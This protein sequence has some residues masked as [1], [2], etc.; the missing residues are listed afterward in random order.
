MELR[1]GWVCPL[2]G[3]ALSPDTKACSCYKK[4]EDI[5][6]PTAKPVENIKDMIRG[7]LEIEDHFKIFKWVK[8][9]PT[10]YDEQPKFKFYTTSSSDPCE[11]CPSKEK[12]FCHCTLKSKVTY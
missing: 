7:P 3:K 2:C 5:V 4:K 12:T 6:K 10:P 1:Y 9:F 11:V 8:D